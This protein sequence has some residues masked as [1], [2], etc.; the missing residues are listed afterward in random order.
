MRPFVLSLQF[1]CE[2][3]AV[4]GVAECSRP[5]WWGLGGPQ[6]VCAPRMLPCLPRYEEERED[7]RLDLE[8]DHLETEWRIVHMVDV[9]VSCW[10][11]APIVMTHAVAVGSSRGAVA[12]DSDS[13]CPLAATVLTC[14]SVH[15]HAHTHFGARWSWPTKRIQCPCRS[16]CT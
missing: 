3:K 2:A 12:C 7:E 14:V 16:Q 5:G 1:S 15:S 13:C 10:F 6:A 8:K 9:D 4:G 11:Y